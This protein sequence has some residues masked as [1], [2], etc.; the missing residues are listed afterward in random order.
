MSDFA[1]PPSW[2]PGQEPERLGQQNHHY[3]TR[4]R[5]IACSTLSPERV[6]KLVKDGHLTVYK[7]ASD[8]KVQFFDLDEINQRVFT[9]VPVPREGGEA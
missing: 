4:Q 5:L 2:L 7:F 1:A 3:I 9:P 8:S 6:T